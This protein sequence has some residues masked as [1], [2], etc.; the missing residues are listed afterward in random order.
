MRHDG[1]QRTPQRGTPQTGADRPQPTK[2]NAKKW[3]RQT[4]THKKCEKRERQTTTHKECEKSDGRTTTRTHDRASLRRV[5][6]RPRRPGVKSQNQKKN[7]ETTSP[8]YVDTPFGTRVAQPRAACHVG[9][10]K[11]F[12]PSVC[13]SVR[14]SVRLSRWVF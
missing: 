7:P 12:C 6:S 10:I 5:A 2:K 1:I 4:T 3:D 13:L 8:P 14:P 11:M 9:K